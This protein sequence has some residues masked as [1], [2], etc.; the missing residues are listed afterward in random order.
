M[1]V[2]FLYYVSGG[3]IEVKDLT[4]NDVKELLLS[5]KLERYLHLF[6]S[7]EITPLFLSNCNSSEEVQELFEAERMKM[8]HARTLFHAI[9]K[10]NGDSK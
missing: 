3:D 10:E 2:S 4:G 1:Y 5:L 9:K 8:A 6:T 7:N